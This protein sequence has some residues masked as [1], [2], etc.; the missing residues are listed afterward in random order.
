LTI[1]WTLEKRLIKDLIPHPK[2]P[3][4]LTKEQFKQIKASIDQFGLIEKIIINS[5]GTII[6]GHQRV[7]VLKKDKVK[8]VD[9]WVPY[10]QLDDKQVEELMIRLNRNHGEFDFEMLANEFEV[11]DL[12]DW[13]FSIQE[14]ELLNIE[15][16]EST[17]PKAKADKLCPHCNNKL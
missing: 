1:E 2:N 6:G 11:P 8:E 17:E 15:E 4:T 12:L 7:E 13:G 5:D 9:C 10:E 16:I 14:M 3:R